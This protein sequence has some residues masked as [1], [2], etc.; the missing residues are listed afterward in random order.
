MAL[1]NCVSSTG[2]FVF[3][4]GRWNPFTGS[5]LPTPGTSILVEV[6]APSIQPETS[7]F[8]DKIEVKISC[9]NCRSY[10]SLFN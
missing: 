10:H 4:V 7:T 5:K 2:W 9:F 3:A 8:T 6:D 1:E